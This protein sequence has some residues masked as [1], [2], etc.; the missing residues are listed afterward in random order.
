[1]KRTGFIAVVTAFCLTLSGCAALLDQEYV[2]VTPYKAVLTT[3]GDPSTLRAESYQEL[4]NALMHFVTTGA[5]TGRIRLYMASEELESE[6][7]AACLEVVQEDPLGAYAVD[8]IKYSVSPVVTYSEAEVQISYRRSREQVDSITSVTGT[9]AIRSAFESLLASFDTEQVLRISYFDGDETF[10]RDLFHQTYYA[11][12]L[13]AVERPTIDV[14][15]YPKT[16]RQRIVELSLD[17]HLDTLRLEA[18]RDDLA[19][20]LDQLCL[21]IPTESSSASELAQVLLSVCRYAPD[22]GATAYH[23]FTEGTANQEGMALA[24]AAL[25]E[26]QEVPCFVVRGTLHNAPHFWNLVRLDS[27]WYHVDL[28]ADVPEGSAPLLLIDSEMAASDYLWTSNSYPQSG[29]ES[30]LPAPE[31]P[32]IPLS[33]ALSQPE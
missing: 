21:T 11:A 19:K 3:E 23:A 9:T 27:E 28:T 22:G 13:S 18:R 16:G 29:K 33:E 31:E 32:E 30:L 25:C 7:D 2:D 4:V 20:Q 12:P 8:Y 26:K 10:I 14:S 15:I 1:M 24:F 5:E 17:Y 6:L